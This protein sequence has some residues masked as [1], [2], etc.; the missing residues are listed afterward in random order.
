MCA[1]ILHEGSPQIGWNMWQ[2]LR[3][4]IPTPSPRH[5]GPNGQVLRWRCREM[6]VGS[7]LLQHWMLLH[8][9]LGLLLDGMML[10][11]VLMHGLML[12]WAPAAA[13]LDGLLNFLLSHAC[14][15]S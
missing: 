9:L 11:W 10:H 14:V 8:R 4:D 7:Q 5:V 2:L 13:L 12:H 3:L 15:L 1:Q 6:L